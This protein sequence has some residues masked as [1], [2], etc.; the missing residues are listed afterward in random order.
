MTQD[1]HVFGPS[2]IIHLNYIPLVCLGIVKRI[3]KFLKQGPRERRLS[4]QQVRILSNK[5][6][7][8]NGKMPREFAPLPRSLYYLDKWKATEFRQLLLYTG[9]LVM[10]SIVPDR[11]YEHCLALTVAISILLESDTQF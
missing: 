9:P 11:L 3:Y 5:L 8:L 4:Q 2:P 1:S 7:F 6:S 10:H